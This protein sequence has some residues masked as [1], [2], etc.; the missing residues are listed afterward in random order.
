M[1]KELV[2]SI[3]IVV[4]I[5]TLDICTQKYTNK[6]INEINERLS[7]IR[8]N[9]RSENINSTEISKKIN[10][11]YEQWLKYHEKL[12]YYIEHNELEKVETDFVTCKSYIESEDYDL[13]I[14]ELEKTMFVLQHINDKYKFN[15]ENIF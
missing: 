7:E 13:A 2:I 8:D 14:A 6:A 3:I 12:V 5:V 10:D 9:I 4:M 15:L 11:I 1:Y